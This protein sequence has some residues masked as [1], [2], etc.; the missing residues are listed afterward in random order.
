MKLQLSKFLNKNKIDTV[1]HYPVAPF[2]QKPYSK[3]QYKIKKFPISI[4][5]QNEAL[6]LPLIS[7]VSYLH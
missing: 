7:N 2:L 4:K 6:S 1:I 3:I 5:F